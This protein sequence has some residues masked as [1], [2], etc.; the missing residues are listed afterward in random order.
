[1]VKSGHNM[2][3]KNEVNHINSGHNMFTDK[4]HKANNDN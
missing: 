3:T 1:M 2:F 4:W